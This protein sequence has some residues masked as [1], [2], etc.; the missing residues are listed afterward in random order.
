M[1]KTEAIALAREY[2][3]RGVYYVPEFRA[4]FQRTIT[5][6]QQGL[7]K[8]RITRAMILLGYDYFDAS[9]YDAGDISFRQAIYGL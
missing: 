6:D 4:W 8:A 3:R 5:L 9:H 7:K 1:S 2:E